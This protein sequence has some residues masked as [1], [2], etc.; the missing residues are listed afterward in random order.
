MN[1]R[2]AGAQRETRPI[3]KPKPSGKL[4][5]MPRPK[6]VRE[7]TPEE[8]ARRFWLEPTYRVLQFPGPDPDKKGAGLQALGE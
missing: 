6:K 4:L 5:V 7:M 1:N 8:M 3:Q 2:G